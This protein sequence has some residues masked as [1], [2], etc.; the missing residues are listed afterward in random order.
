MI[1]VFK[2]YVFNIFIASVFFLSQSVNVNANYLK[3]VPQRENMSVSLMETD[4]KKE[5]SIAAFYVPSSNCLVENGKV[6]KVFEPITLTLG[7]FNTVGALG[8]GFLTGTIMGLF[9]RILGWL[10]GEN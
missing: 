1:K 9:T 7:L 6:V 3:N 10:I 5:I 8:F 4:R 2:N